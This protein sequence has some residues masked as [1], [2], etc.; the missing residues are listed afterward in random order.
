MKSRIVTIAVFAVLAGSVF[1]QTTFYSDNNG[2]FGTANRIGNTTFYSDNNGTFGSAN[3]I[4]NTTFYSDNN[5]TF[6]S[7]NTIGNTTFYSDNNGNFGT[8]NRIGNTT[9]VNTTTSAPKRK[10]FVMGTQSTRFASEDDADAG[11]VPI[12]DSSATYYRSNRQ[13]SPTYPTPPTPPTPSG[14]QSRGSSSVKSNYTFSDA[15]VLSTTVSSVYITRREV[16]LAS[17][18]NILVIQPALDNVRRW[19]NGDSISVYE[20]TDR[21]EHMGYKL[22]NETRGSEAWGTLKR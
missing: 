8:A 7:A 5:G 3:K 2:N 22:V 16:G 13:N 4:G 21:G 15:P 14:Y 9:F 1:S 17:G 18:D 6:G 12:F 10:P 11:S 19:R 20:I